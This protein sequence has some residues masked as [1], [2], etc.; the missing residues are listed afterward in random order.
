MGVVRWVPG[1]RS[2]AS[3]QVDWAWPQKGWVVVEVRVV[4]PSGVVMVRSTKCLSS[5]VVMVPATGRVV[6]VPVV[7]SVTVTLSPGSTSSMFLL[8]P[9]AR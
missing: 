9:S 4:V 3:I 2:P 7:G 6:V 8:E 5:S 1:V